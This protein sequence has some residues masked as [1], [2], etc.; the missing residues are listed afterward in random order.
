MT[1]PGDSL[2]YLWDPSLP[3]D[4]GVKAVED[5]L[6]RLRF[7]TD[8]APLRLESR[9]RARRRFLA[10]AAAAGLL[11]AMAAGF[12]T[13]R[14]QWPAGRPWDLQSAGASRVDV[15]RP[16]TLPE[17]QPALAHIA[18]IGSMRISGGSSFELRATQA[19]RHRLRLYG[20]Q[21]HLRVFA[22]PLS[23]VIETAAGDVIDMGCEF[24][25]DANGAESAVTVLSGWVQ[26]ENAAGE[27]MVPAGASSV[28]R[29]DAPPSVPVFDDAPEEFREMIAALE[30]GAADVAIAS[31][32]LALTARPRDVYTLLHLSSRHPS[33]AEVLLR[34]AAEL[35]P[36]PDDVTVAAIL[37]GDTQA[38][39]AWS[40]ALPLPSPK[41][42]W[43]NWRDLFLLDGI[44]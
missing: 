19:A 38:L 1:R 30:R 9:P 23:V 7:D 20:G 17:G 36:P 22:P 4:P 8:R 2:D 32:R 33:G 16:V 13:W 25:L 15:G 42:W 34:R 12:W 26:M 18:R 5:A 43:R 37:R 35:A 28:M 21:L 14:L 44:R 6:Q 10:L 11:M 29:R 24:Q 41:R 27:V 40:D 39:W 31:S 3:A